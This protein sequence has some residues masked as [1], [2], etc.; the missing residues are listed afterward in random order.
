[1][2]SFPCM[3]DTLISEFSEPANQQFSIPIDLAPQSALVQEDPWFNICCKSINTF[4]LTACILGLHTQSQQGCFQPRAECVGW[5]PDPWG[6]HSVGLQQ[7][8]KD[9][10]PTCGIF[11]S[12]LTSSACFPLKCSP[13]N[14]LVCVCVCNISSVLLAVGKGT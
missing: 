10:T 1:M 4:V 2:S 5:A 14:R 9:G 11:S 7:R 3:S 6:S 8:G 13:L 12:H